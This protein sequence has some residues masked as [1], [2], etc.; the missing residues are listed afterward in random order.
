MESS[1]AA[2]VLPAAEE[3]ASVVRGMFAAI[4]PRY[5]L[6]NHLLSLNRDRAWRRGAVDALL[7]GRDAV[8]T[9]LDACAGT[10]DLACELARRPPFRG[11]VIA[12]DFVVEMLAG[13]A[14]KIGKLPVERV[15]GDA[16]S[17]PLRDASVDGVTVGFGVR[18]LASLESGLRE[19]ARVLRPGAR[20][21]VLEFATP[22]RQP[23]RAL[24]LF[25][26]RRLLPWLGGLVSRHQVAYR[27]LPESV[28][29]FPEPAELA[30]LLRGAGFEAVRWQTCTGGI[31]AV[32]SA[33]RNHGTATAS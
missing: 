7:A 14:A 27:Y 32:H 19:L 8:G 2:S 30:R 22:V 3:K 16:L 31:V 23:L 21:V 15:C 10:L 9:Y 18:N 29:A 1:G 5:D 20:L 28:L 4:A 26:F 11:H 17:L 25:Y 33:E 24:Y 6:L 13:G 12:C